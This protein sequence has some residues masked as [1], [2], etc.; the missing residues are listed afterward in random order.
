M[1]H[2][3]VLIHE[4]IEAMNLK[5]GN[6]VVDCTMGDGGHAELILEAIGP[7]GKLLGIDADPESLLRAKRFL[8]R[9]GEQVVYARDNFENLK[10]IIDEN[11]FGLADAI[12]MDLGWSTPQFEERNR[13]FSF[14]KD[15]PLDMRYTPVNGSEV[16]AEKIINKWNVKELEEIFKRFGEEDLSAEIAGAID[17][18]RKIT[19]IETTRELAE[20]ILQVYRSK[21]KTEK[22]IP[23]IGGIHPATK[24]FQALRIAVNRELEVLKQALPQAYE[25]LASGGRLAVITFHSLEDRIVKHYFQSLPRDGA[26]IITSKPIVPSEA[27]LTVNRRARSAKLRV[28]EKI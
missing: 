17:A 27:E 24:V 3:P 2:V 1:R 15:E 21:L 11:S 4:T 6:R 18:Q 14:E 9:F 19:K 26:T 20:I 7:K 16:T 12:L 8:Y 10:K 5:K 23:W 25:S 13:G 28:I 22:E